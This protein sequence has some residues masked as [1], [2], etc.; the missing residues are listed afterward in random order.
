MC[1]T[2]SAEW[3]DEWSFTYEQQDGGGEEPPFDPQGPFTAYSTLTFGGKLNVTQLP[4]LVAYATLNFSCKLNVTDSP[5]NDTVDIKNPFPANGSTNVDLT[6]ATWNVTIED[7]EG[8]TFNWSIDTGPDVGN[9]SDSGDTNGSKQTSLTGLVVSTTYTVWVNATDLGNG[10]T[11]TK[12]YSFTTRDTFVPSP[13]S[14]FTA[15]TASADKIDLSWDDNDENRTVIEWNSAPNWDRGDGTEIYNNTGTS[16]AHSGLEPDTTYYYQA[17]SYNGTDNSYSSTNS[18]ASDTT[19]PNTPPSITG[20]TP[21]NASTVVITT[22]SVN[23]TITDD[24]GDEFN[25]TIELSDGNNDGANGASNGSKVC[26]LTPLTYGLTYTWWVNVTDGYD[27]VTA[28]Y[29]FDAEDNPMNVTV[30]GWTGVEETNF[31]VSGTLEV[32][33]ADGTTCFIQAD[34]DPGFGSPDANQS[35]GIIAESGSFTDDITG[36]NPGTLYYV[37]TV[38]NDSFGW[39]TSWN[40]T[41]ILTKPN[42]PTSLTITPISGGFNVSWTHGTGYQKSALYFNNT[43]WMD[44][45]ADGT[46]LYLDTDNYYHH[47]GLE[48]GITYYYRVWEY[49]ENI[50]Y[51]QSHYSDGNE[52]ASELYESTQAILKNPN[53]ADGA[54]GVSIDQ[55]TWNIT[56]ENPTGG[57]IN[58]SIESSIGSNSSTGASNGSIQIEI[59]GNLTYGMTYIIYV[60]ASGPGLSNDTNETYTFTVE[61]E[62]NAPTITSPDPA[63]QSSGISTSLSTWS[64]S[65]TDGNGDTFNW[66]I[67]VSN[68]DSNSANDDSNG[69]K[70]VSLSTPLTPNARFDVWVNATDGENSTTKAYYFTTGGNFSTYTTLTFGTKFDCIGSN[71]EIASIYPLNTSTDIPMYPTLIVNATEPQGQNFNITWSTNATGSWVQFNVSCINGSYTQ[72][73]TWANESDTTYWWTVALNDT[74]GNWYNRT[75]SFT[76]A[77][78]SWTNWSDWWTFTYGTTSETFI[79]NPYPAN[80]STGVERPPTNISA[81]VNGTGLDIYYYFYNMTPVVDQ[82]DLFYSW[83]GETSDRFEYDTSNGIP[84]GDDT[85]FVWGNT[86]Y[87]WRVAVDN[88]TGW[89]NVSYW[90]NTTGSRYDVTN[91]GDVVATDVAVAWSK[92]TGQATYNG[93]YDVTNSGDIVATDM[94]AIWANRT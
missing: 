53:P 16:Y 85:R 50:P 46:L 1:I 80:T 84:S 67:E 22:A 93:I 86:Q 35:Q 76:T 38:C 91:S 88:G 6:Q 5:G 48:D 59:A 14:S 54:T 18:T 21:T 23:V 42:T 64:V 33:G 62:N 60:N 94:S 72:V 56:A 24:N 70:S 69:T 36:L 31:T 87:Q 52:S 44:T 20:E 57:T 49:V 27:S 65:I 2:V 90:Y 41:H 12:V 73:A 13:P 4:P 92:R 89:T 79:Q 45:R 37:R 43:T 68:G 39:N 15:T 71:P 3:S 8:D 19:D 28:V 83:S 26:S 66:T 10:T 58:W 25:W 51:S 40:V 9:A 55:A 7:P 61:Q 32:E 17:W 75:Y 77:E 47:T 34:D 29:T 78:Y 11:V 63:N 82:W 30:T 81:F 74:I